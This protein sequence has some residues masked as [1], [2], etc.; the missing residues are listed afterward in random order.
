MPGRAALAVIAAMW[1]C[2]GDAAS[3]PRGDQTAAKL[4]LRGRAPLG[5]GSIRCRGF[6]LARDQR[7]SPVASSTRKL[8][9]GHPGP[10]PWLV[11]PP[12]QHIV[13]ARS[14]LPLPDSVLPA[15]PSCQGRALA[16]PLYRQAVL[17]SG[18]HPPAAQRRCL[19]SWGKGVPGRCSSRSAPARRPPPPLT[20][21]RLSGRPKSKHSHMR[22]QRG[23]RGRRPG[24][25]RPGGSLGASPEPL[26]RKKGSD[27]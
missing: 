18:T 4:A 10:A 9:R 20:P 23:L 12:I 16:F 6:R 24:A 2:P 21:A 1:L 25:A 5:G 27:D 22:V 19:H 26:P 14:T 17:H 13:C 11:L 15:A 7:R 3:V 8:G